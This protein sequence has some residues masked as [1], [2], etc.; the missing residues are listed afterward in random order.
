[1]HCR[2]WVGRERQPPTQACYRPFQMHGSVEEHIGTAAL[3]GYSLQELGPE[4]LEAADGHLLICACL[5]QPPGGNRTIQHG[6]PHQGRPVLFADRPIAGRFIFRTPWGLP[7]RRPGAATWISPPPA[8][9][10]SAGSEIRQEPNRRAME[11][12]T[13]RTAGRM[14]S[15]TS[16]A[17][18]LGPR[19]NVHPCAS[20]GEPDHNTGLRVE[21]M[22]F[23]LTRFASCRGTIPGSIP[24]RAQ[25]SGAEGCTHC[26]RS[27]AL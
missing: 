11:E 3:E 14:N 4:A 26:R 25:M 20:R 10:C 15:R 5:P 23:P 6:S 12:G 13:A 18:R 1:M 24:L 2:R 17:D 16:A 9:T 21:A 22:A 19:T 7:D 27:L 8:T